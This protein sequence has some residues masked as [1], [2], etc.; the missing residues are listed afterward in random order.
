MSIHWRLPT[1]ILRTQFARAPAKRRPRYRARKWRCQLPWRFPD[2]DRRCSC[3]ANAESDQM[4]SNS[5]PSV[6]RSASPAKSW[7][8]VDLPGRP[9]H[10]RSGAARHRTAL[11]LQPGNATIQKTMIGIG[12]RGGGKAESDQCMFMTDCSERAFYEQFQR[13]PARPNGVHFC[14]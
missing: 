6:S 7:P 2:S 10:I 9:D 8:S 11:Q 3:D 4:V 14:P 12:Y 5:E 1:G 13:A